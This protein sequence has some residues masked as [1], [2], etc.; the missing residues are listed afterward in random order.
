MKKKTELESGGFGTR[1]RGKEQAQA[2]TV[3]TKPSDSGT[4]RLCTA[5]VVSRSCWNAAHG[6]FTAAFSSH[7]PSPAGAAP[8]IPPGHPHPARAPTSRGTARTSHGE[9]RWY[10]TS[11][12][13]HPADP[14]SRSDISHRAQAPHTPPRHFTSREEHPGDSTLREKHPRH[15]TS[16]GAAGT[17]HILPRKEQTGHPISRVPRGASG[18][19]HMP[20]SPHPAGSR[21]DTPHP[22]GTPH[23]PPRCVR[24]GPPPP[25]VT[26]GRAPPAAAR[27]RSSA[28]LPPAGMLRERAPRTRGGGEGHVRGRR[29]CW[30]CSS[31]RS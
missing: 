18:A 13:Q 5:P 25:A 26:R 31:T 24:L 12:G 16:Q 29:C 17:A 14:T 1:C 21:L 27:P 11:R 2:K 10:P 22:A 4:P 30:R 19:P 7:S 15:P 28:A 8:R 23:I 6:A 9:H 3:P 20:D